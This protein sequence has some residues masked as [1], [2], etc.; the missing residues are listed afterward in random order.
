MGLDKSMFNQPNGTD[1]RS[2]VKFTESDAVVDKLIS[3]I[4][5]TRDRVTELEETVS[6]QQDT[7]AE[8]Q[9]TID[10]QATTIEE[11]DERIDAL[12]EELASYRTENERDKA[13]IRSTV[14]DADE[15]SSVNLNV[16]DKLNTKMK[17]ITG[18][19]KRV[20][21]GRSSL[22]Q[23]VRL[24]DA[25]ATEALSKNQLRSRAIVSEIK[26]VKSKTAMKGR[27][28]I[29]SRAIRDKLRETY[30]KAHHQT[31]S[32]VMEFIEEMGGNDVRLKQGKKRKK[33]V[34][35]PELIEQLDRAEQLDGE[36]IDDVH[37]NGVMATVRGG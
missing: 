7:L 18:E 27:K 1:G 25:I 35:E 17:E 30:S 20:N 34:F 2:T 12:E 4:H 33:L 11:Q 32:R 29:D 3:A 24:P 6:E 26:S 5:E 13:D 8:Q 9:E 36:E 31:V 22:E 15:Q 21:G 19:L 10:E 28:V 37:T 14:T 23:I 16:I